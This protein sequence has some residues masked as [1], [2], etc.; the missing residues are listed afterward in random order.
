MARNAVKKSTELESGAQ[1]QVEADKPQMAGGAL[2]VVPSRA[3]PPRVGVAQVNAPPARGKQAEVPPA[4]E[5][6]VKWAPPNGVMYD[7]CRVTLRPGKV[8]TDQTYNLGLLT[9][10][11]VVLE[12]ILPPA[13][14]PKVEE[15]PEATEDEHH[16]TTAAE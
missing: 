2:G 1:G 13:P 5:F 12:E 7:N 9:R 8:V 3:A 15:L 16:P 14:A 4:R 10:Q 11:G 6:R